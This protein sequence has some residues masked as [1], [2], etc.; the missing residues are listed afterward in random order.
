MVVT[1][2]LCVECFALKGE[3]HRLEVVVQD[4][5]WS[6]GNDVSGRN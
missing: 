2:V 5:F 4:P 1:Y 6:D 3:D